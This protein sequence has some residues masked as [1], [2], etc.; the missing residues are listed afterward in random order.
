MSDVGIESVSRR[1]NIGSISSFPVVWCL[2]TTATLGVF[3][4]SLFIGPTEIPPSAFAASLV[5]YDLASDAHVVARD[6]RLPR[7]LLALLV[8]GSL[9]AAGTTMQGVTRNPLA[10]PSIMGLSGGGALATLIALILVPGLSYNA[11]IAASLLG[12]TLG[13]GCVLAVACLSPNGF[14][15][16]RITLAGAVTSSFLSSLTQGLVIAFAMSGSML[17]WTVGG[18]SNVTWPQVAA[19]APGCLVGWAGLLWLA[20]TVTILGLGNDVAVGLGVRTRS[21]RIAATIC[22]LVLTGGAVA[23]AGPVA[24]VGVM[25]PHVCRSLVGADYRRLIPLSIIAGAGLTGLADLLSRTVA[26]DGGEI[27]LGVVTA[28]LGAPCFVWLIRGTARKR[29]DGGV[30][31]AVNSAP[32]THWPS[33]RAFPLL[34]GLLSLSVIISVHVG[35]VYYSPATIF[36]TLL[37]EGLPEQNLVLW[38]FRFPRVMFALLVGSGIA[39]A[40]AVM[41]GVLRNDLVE[42]GILG[43]SSGAS[44]AIVLSLVLL[45]HAILQSALI[46]PL[47]AIGGALAAVLLIWLLCLNENPSSPRLLLTGVAVSAALGAVAL[48][49]STQIES[50]EYA[51]SV[52]FS[53]GSLSGAGWNYVIAL[54]IWLGLLGPLVWT[55]SPTLDVLALGDEVATGLGVL[56][57]IVSMLLLGMAVLICAACMSLAGGILFLG[58][59][60][61][62]IARRLVGTSHARLI[63]ASG[64]IG[65]TLLAWADLAGSHLI[66]GIVLPAG[67]MVSALGAPYF[68]FLL[69]RR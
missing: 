10:G 20:P 15:P 37:G 63:P 59:I 43:V 31:G 25:V 6:V 58:L 8:G 24:F 11:S 39:V 28:A 61:P 33:R 21:I 4:A 64:I 38:S 29:L 69:T 45:G 22:V 7:A 57:R 65:A 36:Q 68:L 42:P 62:H 41:Q 60:A 54:A 27:P 32:V 66:P 40:G 23:V 2:V 5:D 52:A 56:V 18:I 34:L 1:R 44:L 50:D 26:G 3:V 17:F 16:T 48:L 9:A 53:A 67:V 14:S 47:A 19:V 46:L 12:A 51:F 30:P 49:V 35:E 55:F 13:Y